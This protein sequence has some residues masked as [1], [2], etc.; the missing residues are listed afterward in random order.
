MINTFYITTKGRE[1]IAQSMVDKALVFTRGEFGKGV[2]AADVSPITLT[3]LVSPQGPLNITRK[4]ADGST[5]TITTEFSN[6]VNGALLPA[7][8]LTEVGLYGKLQTLTGADDSPETLILYGCVPSN[9]ADDIDAVDTSYILNWPLVVSDTANVSIEYVDTQ[10]V[11]ME[12]FEE[13][14]AEIEVQSFSGYRAVTGNS[15]SGIASDSGIDFGK[16]QG[17][18]VQDGTPTPE[19]PVEIQSWGEGMNVN[20]DGGN[21]FDQSQIPTFTAG[22]ATITNNGDGSFTVSGTGEITEEV[23]F[24]KTYS[25]E[26]TLKMLR[27]GEITLGS[28]EANVYPRLIVQFTQ[29]GA[30]KFVLHS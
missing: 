24:Y 28:V 11:D 20:S 21:L 18:S 10:H 13:A 8:R 7:F 14:M 1:Y 19:A 3:A 6:R 22:G 26:E 27:V 4:E 5:T 2:P 29:N 30:N 9:Q 12:S 17:K 16:V 23:S 25:H 15:Y